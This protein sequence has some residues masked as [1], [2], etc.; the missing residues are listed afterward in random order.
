MKKHKQVRWNLK[1]SLDYEIWFNLMNVFNNSEYQYKMWYRLKNELENKVYVP[2]FY[3]KY[4]LRFYEK[5]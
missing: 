2:K 4:Y 3:L 5:T 1:D